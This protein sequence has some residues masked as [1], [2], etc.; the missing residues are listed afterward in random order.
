MFIYSDTLHQ[1]GDMLF[2]Q[3]ITRDGSRIIRGQ[4]RIVR[5]VTEGEGDDRRVGQAVEFI[6]FD[7]EDS[8]F[9]DDLVR[10]FLENEGRPVLRVGR[11]SSSTQLPQSQS[12]AK[13]TPESD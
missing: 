9:V 7:E 3:F 2:V 12:S 8:R 13:T 4:G 10:R 11:H 6:D 5:V 1:V